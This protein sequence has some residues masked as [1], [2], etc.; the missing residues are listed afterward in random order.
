MFDGLSSASQPSPETIRPGT[1]PGRVGR[2]CLQRAYSV[3]PTG[4]PVNPVAAPQ[5]QV[6]MRGLEPLTSALQKQRSPN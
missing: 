1:S 5:A 2:R 6:E 4:R 3:G